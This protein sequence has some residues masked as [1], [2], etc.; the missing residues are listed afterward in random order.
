[1]AAATAARDAAA[2]AAARGGVVTAT[3][4]ERGVAGTIDEQRP[5]RSTRFWVAAGCDIAE[6][7]ANSN[8]DT[9]FWA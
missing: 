9:S 4:S 3:S 6:I 5:R 1:M 8:Q 2:A 7:I